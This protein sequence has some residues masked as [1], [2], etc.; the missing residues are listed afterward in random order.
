MPDELP[1]NDPGFGD[2]D[3]R[4]PEKT[5]YLGQVFND[6]T[7]SYKLAWFI[8]ILSLV[9]RSTQ[10]SLPLK[11]ILVEMAVVAWPPVCLYRLSL[12]RQDKLQEAVQGIRVRSGLPPNA[13]PQE[14]RN[15]INGMPAAQSDL[16]LLL[17]Y[18]PT[19]FLAPWFAD[20]LRGVPDLRRSTV[21]QKLAGESQSTPLACPY[22]FIN[23]EI[24]LN[25]GWRSF[26]SE[27]AAVVR[28]FAEHHLAQYLQARNPNVPGVIN[29]LTVPL[30]R[31]LS[32]AITFWRTVRAELDRQ[33]TPGEIVDIYT[34]HP[35]PERFSIDHFLPWSFVAHDLLWNLTPVEPVTNSSKS[36]VV[37][38]LGLYLPRMAKLQLS[39]IQALQ[40]RERLL[41]DYTDCFQLDVPGLMS[42]GE[43]GLLKRY[44]A[45]VLPQA[46]IAINQGFQAG[47]RWQN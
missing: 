38:D 31:Q 27:N 28:A 44:Q 37:P 6:T 4:Y 25:Q 15:H 19:R 42:L 11:D 35:L 33:G 26:L 21:I 32:A 45:V 17:R 7:N 3:R 46:Q 9:E 24:R 40:G 36:D 23:G 39:A 29:K 34:G 16:A 8:A 5:F 12:G 1:V 18:V 41:E 13:K 14:I 2:L 20:Q 22:W 10:R 43:E 30:V 47:W